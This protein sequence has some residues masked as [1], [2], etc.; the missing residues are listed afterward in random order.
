MT[1]EEIEEKIRQELTAQNLIDILK[2]CEPDTP[3]I[4]NPF[5]CDYDSNVFVLDKVY[6][7]FDKEGKT[8]H[9]CINLVPIELL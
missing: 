5:I 1:N 8:T 4:F 3:V 9:N 7:C 6:K 2:D